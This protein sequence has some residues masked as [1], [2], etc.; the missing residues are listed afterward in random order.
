MVPAVSQKLPH[1]GLLQKTRQKYKTRN[2]SC[3]IHLCQLQYNTRPEWCHAV[4]VILHS[5]T[6]LQIWSFLVGAFC[7]Y[8]ELWELLHSSRI[9]GIILTFSA[10]FEY[11]VLKKI[12]IYI[13]VVVVVVVVVGSRAQVEWKFWVHKQSCPELTWRFLVK[14]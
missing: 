9:I 5:N 1:Q 4:V 8:E 14:S 13:W 3:H 6:Q 2:C 10:C 11:A 7:C 12:Y